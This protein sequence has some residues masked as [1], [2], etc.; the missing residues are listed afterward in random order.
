MR[1]PVGLLFRP[2]TSTLKSTA[3]DGRL[4]ELLLLWL[5]FWVRVLILRQ[6]DLAKARSETLFS[7]SKIT[8]WS[9]NNR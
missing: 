8:Q 9:A 5:P 7:Q 6:N 1:F 3:A 2:N 4:F